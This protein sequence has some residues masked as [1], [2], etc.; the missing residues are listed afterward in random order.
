MAN[1]V[2]EARELLSMGNRYKVQQ[3]VS[4]SPLSEF[5]VCSKQSNVP[6][7]NLSPSQ[8]L[9]LVNMLHGKEEFGL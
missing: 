1:L 2:W 7:P 6:A 4:S 5:Q 9:E 8:P 3:V